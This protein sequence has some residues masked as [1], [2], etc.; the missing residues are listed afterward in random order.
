MPSGF[1]L[2]GR[3]AGIL[4]PQTGHSAKGDW[5]RQDFI[6]EVQDGNFPTSVCFSLWG[7]D[8]VKEL[9]KCAIGT[10]VKVSFNLSSREY[11]GR[12][13]T[14]IRAWRVVAVN[15]GAPAGGPATPPPPPAVEDLPSADFGDD[16]PF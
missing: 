2:E 16:L 8:R 6:V 9:E 12:W 11:N 13:Y 10:Q 5:V 15:E 4:E 7:A 3:L 14:D 1:E